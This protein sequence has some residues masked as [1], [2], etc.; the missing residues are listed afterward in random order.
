MRHL[1]GTAYHPIACKDSLLLDP[2]NLSIG[3]PGG[4][5]GVSLH[6]RVGEKLRSSR[7]CEGVYLVCLVCCINVSVELLLVERQVGYHSSRALL[8]IFQV[9]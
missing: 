7:D 8:L 3:V 1:Q 9:Q 6:C 4:R 2:I 5:R